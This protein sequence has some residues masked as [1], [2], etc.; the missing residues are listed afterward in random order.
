M[1]FYNGN[2]QLCTHNYA[3]FTEEMFTCHSSKQMVLI[4]K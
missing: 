4:I 1:Y 2:M 3:F